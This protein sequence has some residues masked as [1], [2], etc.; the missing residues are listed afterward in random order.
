[1]SMDIPFWHCSKG[2]TCLVVVYSLM[3]TEALPT[4]FV[5]SAGILDVV[6]YLVTDDPRRVDE[7]RQRQVALLIDRMRISRDVV[8]P[9]DHGQLTRAACILEQ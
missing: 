2:R 7:P 6:A 9:V 8:E 5:D 1:M 4:E 3:Q